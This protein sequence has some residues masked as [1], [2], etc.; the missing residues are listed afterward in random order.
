ML[1]ILQCISAF[2]PFQLM[3]GKKALL[4]IE[5]EDMDPGDFKDLSSNGDS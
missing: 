3:F 1:A 4:P 5:V 2:T